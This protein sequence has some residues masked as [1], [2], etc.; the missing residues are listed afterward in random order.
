MDRED[1]HTYELLDDAKG[2]FDIVGNQLQVKDGSLLDFDNNSSHDLKIRTTD[3]GGKSYDKT[4]SI[5]VQNQNNAPTDINL[6][7]NSVKEFS[8]NGT[9]I[10]TLTTN[11]VDA[12]DHHKY[13]L[14]HDAKGRFKIDGNQ[15]KVKNGHLLDFDENSSHDLKIRTTDSGG[16]SYDKTFTIDVLNQNNAPTD[17]TISGNSVKEFSN[18]G[19]TIA[20]LTTNGT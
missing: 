19:T 4:F 14:L 20:T 16:K 1:N 3:S 10:A 18:N 15:L 12:G 13:K 9:T 17:I 5:Q 2:R 6:S 8:N 7:S 11:D